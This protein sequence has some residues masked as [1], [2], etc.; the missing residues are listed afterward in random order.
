MPTTKVGVTH[1]AKQEGWSSRPRSGRGGGREYS[2]KV[3]PQEARAAL[4]TRLADAAPAP[5]EQPALPALPA[6]ATAQMANWQRQTMDARAVILAELER[7]AQVAGITAAIAEMVGRAKADTLPQHLKQFVGVA[8]AR[9]GKTGGRTLSV[10]TLYRWRSEAKRGVAALAPVA[11]SLSVAPP[12]WAPAFHKEW[13]GPTK[14]KLSEVLRTMHKHL[15]EGVAMPS[16][17]AARRYLDKLSPLEREAGRHGPNGMLQFLPYKHRSVDGLPPMA[18]VTADGHTFKAWVRNP[19]SGRSFNPEVAVVM[20]TATRY[21]LGFSTALA[22]S[23]QAIRDAIRHTVERFGMFGLFYTDNGSG[24][25]AKAMTSDAVGLLARI[26]A[27]PENSTP[28]RA[29][30]RGKIEAFMKVLR[31]A[32]RDLPTYTGRDVDREFKKRLEKQI[33]KDTKATGTSRRVISWEDFTAFLGDVFDRYNMKPHRGLPKFTDGNGVKRHM[34]PHDAM[35]HW[36]AQGWTPRMA[37]ASMLDDLFRPC[38]ERTVTRGLVPLGDAKYF[39]ADLT[40]FHGRRVR[41]GYDPHDPSKVWVR[42]LEDDR[43][44]CEATLN[45]HH[46]EQ[47]PR[48][49]VQIAQDKRNDRQ[50]DLHRKAVEAIED[51]RRGFRVIEN[52]PQVAPHVLNHTIERAHAELPL[53]VAAPVAL[54]QPTET[55]EDRWWRRASGLQAKLDAGETL[56]E[57]DAHWLAVNR[58]EGWFKARL[59]AAQMAASFPN[60]ARRTA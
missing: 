60:P 21:L 16:P 57:A 9:A 2:I 11:P 25:I 17:S 28:G 40:P 45:G 55:H 10:M 15:P 30:A 38:E 53:Q 13:N 37:P 50:V 49:M 12:A 3:L 33:S 39:A 5:I 41:V 42:T 47:H 51:E 52:A 1:R 36:R 31:A 7:L 19:R 44:I 8:N 35:E 22:E 23:S 29:Q 26:G 24:F 27:S 48:S 58:Q 18:T 59:M 14:R 20:D 4:V 34:S 56:S 54:I 43:F 32:A 6:P 46:T